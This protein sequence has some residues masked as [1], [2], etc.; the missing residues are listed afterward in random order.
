LLDDG[1]IEPIELEWLCQLHLDCR[2]LGGKASCPWGTAQDPESVAAD[3]DE[4]DQWF[5]TGVRRSVVANSLGF[6]LKPATDTS[7]SA[8]SSSTT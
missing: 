2:Q 7:A 5:S 4:R 3:A 8:R 6:T 1:V